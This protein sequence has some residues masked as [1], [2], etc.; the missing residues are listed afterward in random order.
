MPVQGHRH[1]VLRRL[2][3]RS[4]ASRDL[5]LAYIPCLLRAP[6]Q[7]LF[8]F[9][10]RAVGAGNV[11]NRAEVLPQPTCTFECGISALAN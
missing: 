6:V 2:G 7:N 4:R 11:M 8:K 10:S 5:P 1:T 9:N 3:G